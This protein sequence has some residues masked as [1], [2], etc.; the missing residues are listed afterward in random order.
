MTTVQQRASGTHRVRPSITEH[1]GEE[2][3]GSL[4]QPRVGHGLRGAQGLSPE[5]FLSIG[6]NMHAIR[7][8]SCSGTFLVRSYF[9]SFP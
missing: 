9:V 8:D 1:C 4:C 2:I 5:L 6:G 7:A 3:V